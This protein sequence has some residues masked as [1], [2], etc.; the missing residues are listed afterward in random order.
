V[1]ILDPCVRIGG[2]SDP[3]QT[4]IFELMKEHFTS[5]SGI[6][7]C[8]NGRTENSIKNY[9]YSTIRRIQSLEVFDYFM[10]MRDGKKL[11]AVDSI[12]TFEKEYQLNKLN[13]LG[14]II[15]KWLYQNDDAKKEHLA[16]FEYLLK[17]VAD[18]KKRPPT[19][20][21]KDIN[22]IESNSANH[23]K[24][25]VKSGKSQ[26]NMLDETVVTGVHP[27]LPAILFG[28]FKGIPMG[29]LP[30]L[31]LS[32]Y[33]QPRASEAV[34]NGMYI[35]KDALKSYGLGDISIP[36]PQTRERQ[37][38]SD[39]NLPGISED[40]VFPQT[41][42]NQLISSLSHNLALSNKSSKAESSHK[43]AEL[44]VEAFKE[45]KPTTQDGSSF[46]ADM[47]D[48]NNNGFKSRILHSS[49][50]PVTIPLPCYAQYGE[51]FTQYLERVVPDL[52]GT[53]K[54]YRSH[55]PGQEKTQAA[56]LL[57]C[58]KCMVAKSECN[59]SL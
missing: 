50:S 9:F 51:K 6:S 53:N 55:E 41:V 32:N 16:L 44:P 3:E 15:C 27:L 52:K 29:L 33:N 24:D 28:G 46:D 11:P 38:H 34:F 12:D 5:W 20:A 13:L 17:M 59:C 45:V 47:K 35:E 39:R 14:K 42:L 26:S 48:P 54:A 21:S 18:E 30:R 8:L 58:C 22:S 23:R 10:L 37:E 2:W 7:K 40:S 4:K 25:A 56:N 19:K 43:R 36:I 57:M 1:N 31:M 49:F